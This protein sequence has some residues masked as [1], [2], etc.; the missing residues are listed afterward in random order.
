MPLPNARKPIPLT[1]KRKGR[2]HQRL[3][4]G[5][6]VTVERNSPNNFPLLSIV[7]FSAVWTVRAKAQS[8][9]SM[10]ARASTTAPVGTLDP[11]TEHPIALQEP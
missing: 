8:H 6:S 7:Y 10:A 4:T 9:G 3:G 1:A 5:L 11:N 2:Y